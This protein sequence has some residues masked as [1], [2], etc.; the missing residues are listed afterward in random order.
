MPLELASLNAVV[1]RSGHETITLVRINVLRLVLLFVS[2][3]A[4][5]ASDEAVGY[6]RDVLPILAD[7]CFQCHG[8]DKAQRK[9]GLRLD[10]AAGAMAVLES[11]ERA[12]TPGK[13]AESGLIE[14]ILTTD[15]DDLM[16][17]KKTGKRLTAEQKET[18]RRWVEQGAKYEP[19]WAYIPPVR[20]ELPSVPGSAHPVDRFI[21]ARLAQENIA[22][23]PDL[24]CRC[25]PPRMEAPS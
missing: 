11:G 19:H 2:A 21:R 6:N 25:K 18:L 7:N 14:R 22:L 10:S 16:P 3:P 9:A 1:S 8:F 17:P 4:F 5:G 12:I 20:L 23:A 15:A 13:V 24:K